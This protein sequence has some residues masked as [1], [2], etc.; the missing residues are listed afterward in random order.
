LVSIDYKFPFIHKLAN[1]R[2]PNGSKAPPRGELGATGTAT[3]ASGGSLVLQQE[4]YNPDLRGAEFFKTIDRMRLSDS[5]VKAV[6]SILKLPLLAADWGFESPSDD[7]QSVEIAEWLEDRFFN[8]QQ[9]TWDYTLRH[10]LLSLDYGSMPFE[11][12]WKVVD[13]DIL[14]RPMV[15]LH[16]LAP[17]MP[18]TIIEWQLTDEGELAGIKQQVEKDGMF[19]EITIPGDRLICFVHDMEGAN[20]K[21][22]SILRQARK[23]WLIK[24]RLQRINQVAIEKRAAGVDVGEIDS[25]VIKDKTTKEAFESVLQSIR[26]HE[27]G[28]V[29]LPGGHKYSIAGIQGA[30]LDP[31]PS[32]QYCDVMI[33][34]S[35]LAD[36]LIAG[37]GS[38]GSFALVKD[39]SSFFLM[40]LGAIADELRAPINRYLIPRWVQWNWPSVTEFPELVHSRLDRRDVKS[41]ADA[42]AVLIPQGVVTP[43]GEIER[44]MRELLELPELP[45]E[46]IEPLE[47][48]PDTPEVTEEDVEED[49]QINEP[50][51]FTA[52]SPRRVFRPRTQ[53]ERAVDWHLLARSLEDTEDKIVREYRKVQAKQIDKLV[54]EAMKAI[55][56]EDKAKGAA[57]LENINIP[58]KQEAADLVTKP[59]IDLYRLGQNEVKREMARMG[60]EPLRLASPLDVEEDTTILGY[61]RVRAK[62]MVQALASRLGISIFENGLKMIAKGETDRLV[63]KGALEALSERAIRSE[64]RLGVSEALNL[65]RESTARRNELLVRKAEY[66]AILDDGTCPI[67]AKLDGKDLEFGSDEYEEVKPPNRNCEGGNRCRCT[68][69]FT[70]ASEAPARR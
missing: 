12:V 1:G 26:T 64:A 38:E 30:V 42:L 8:H 21:G 17:R 51:V 18:A 34:R 19:K 47:P 44:E 62:K 27:R 23:D 36:F 35:I 65:G 52:S 25:T 10:M 58:Y 6:M 41:L 32:I 56:Q 22:T 9:R 54:D 53:A 20:Y 24:E 3:M 60:G 45:D 69:I 57:M 55:N 4:D 50:A 68:V 66:S 43:D 37:T 59:L 29:L 33:L 15:H 13:D 61:L 31:L 14:N 48:P 63:L 46:T 11:P 2:S 28:Y 39:R 7:P 16:K 40:A 5:Q 49:E 70:F 67:C